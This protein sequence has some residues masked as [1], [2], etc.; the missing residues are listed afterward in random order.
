[1]KR[2]EGFLCILFPLLSVG[3]ML[4]L[5]SH[6]TAA[7]TEHIQNPTPTQGGTP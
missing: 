6:A 5:F 7:L 3:M 2:W 4:W 1:M